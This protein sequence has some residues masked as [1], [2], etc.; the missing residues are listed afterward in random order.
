MKKAIL[1]SAMALA[2]MS[3]SSCG[4]DFLTI[5]AAGAVG[6]GTLMNDQGIEFLLTGAYSSLNGMMPGQWSNPANTLAN[7]VFGDMLGADTNEGTQAGDQPDWNALEVYTITAANPY[8]LQKWQAIYEVVK[9]CN[10]ILSILNRAGDKINNADVIAGQAQF[11]KA[12]W[13]FE[14]IRMFGA[15]IPYVSVE[16]YDANVDPQV[17]NHSEGSNVAD[18]Y[19]WSNVEA[20]LQD[21]I[22]KLPETWTEGNYGRANKTMAKALLGKLYL[23]W[24]SPYTGHNGSD[25]SK[26]SQA[27]SLLSEVLSSGKDAKG[28]SFKMVDNYA[29]LFQAGHDWDGEGII[30]IQLTLDGS[31]IWTAA[32]YGGYY[33]GF[34]NTGGTGINTGWGFIQPTYNFVNSMIVDENG[35]PAADF[36][37]RDVP[38]KFTEVIDPETGKVIERSITTDLTIVTDPRLDISMGRAGVPFLDWGVAPEAAW[39]RSFTNAGVY[40]TKKHITRVSE[41][42]SQALTNY[43]TSNVKNH[44]IMRVA[45]V[46][47]MLAEIAIREN[48]LGTALTLINEVRTRAAN[49]Y[50]KALD[51]VTKG[52]YTYVNKITG[53]TE[54]DAAANYMIGLYPAFAS[55]DE[56]WTALKRERRAEL[57]FEGHRFFDLARWG[58]VGT[59]LGKYVAFEKQYLA[60]Y[61]TTPGNFTCMPIPLNEIRASEGRFVQ[62]A[63][64]Q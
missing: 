39:I 8:I 6:E 36:E 31:S 16:D 25:P 26:L 45:D 63:D 44:R 46:K 32:V 1:Y 2:T 18:L 5:E 37:S 64:W 17:T 14:G 61:Q 60:K 62:N 48:D 57:S 13:L 42:G 4:D 30:D 27:K 59:T 43:G 47:L 9:R 40:V 23:Y 38:T 3:L 52:S 53:K 33:T 58:D 15:A 24:S 10:N 22:N 50:V 21:A 35:L 49:S 55:A 54:T 51:G 28:Q 34:N 29:D 20:D 41:L 19:I 11:L 56:A 7:P 12:L